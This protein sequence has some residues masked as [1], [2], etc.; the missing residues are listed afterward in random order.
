MIDFL[1][2]KSLSE[3]TPGRLYKVQ[4]PHYKSPALVRMS[5]TPQVPKE[6]VAMCTLRPGPTCIETCL[7]TAR[8]AL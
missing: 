2:E 6:R 7:S 3:I 8:P 5:S 1:T 4:C